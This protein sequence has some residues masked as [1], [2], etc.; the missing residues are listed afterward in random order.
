MEPEVVVKQ[1]K[2]MGRDVFAIESV[3][4][5]LLGTARRTRKLVSDLMQ[6]I[7]GRCRDQA[8]ASGVGVAEEWGR[9]HRRA[10]TVLSVV[11]WWLG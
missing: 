4:G 11:S 1:T 8:A 3:S 6:V 9:A 7:Q 10:S 5:E 2:A